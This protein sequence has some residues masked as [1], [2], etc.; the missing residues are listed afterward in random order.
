MTLSSTAIDLIMQFGIVVNTKCS[1]KEFELV[2]PQYLAAPLS[3][4]ADARKLQVVVL[5]VIILGGYERDICSAVQSCWDTFSSYDRVK[6]HRNLP[7][8]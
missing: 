4:L 5:A 2:M 6:L 3:W 1:S 8:Y 7:V